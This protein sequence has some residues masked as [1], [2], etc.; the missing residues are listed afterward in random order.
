MKKKWVSFFLFYFITFCA[1]AQTEGYNYYSKLDTVKSSGFYNIALTPEIN[2]HL[3]T[4][5]S[6]IRIVNDSGKWVPHVFRV[7]QTEWN[8]DAVLWSMPVIKKENNLLSTL[9]VVKNNGSAISGI[10]INIRNTQVER[11]CTLTG[12]DD[13]TNWF[14]INDS[15]LLKPEPAY[16]KYQSFLK[17]NFPPATY[18][19]FKLGI[20]NKGK[21]PLNIVNVYS[22]ATPPDMKKPDVH[23]YLPFENPHTVIVQKDSGELSFVKVTQGTAYHFDIISLKTDGAKYF[24]RMVDMYVPSDSNQSFAHPGTLVSSF[25]IS[26]NSTLR[27]YPPAT[28]TKVFYLLIHNQDNPPLRLT[29]V[30]TYSTYHMLTAYLEHGRIYRLLLDNPDATKPHFDLSGDFDTLENRF[31]NTIPYLQ[32]GKIEETEK[33]ISKKQTTS[34]NNKLILWSAIVIAIIILLFFTS[35]MLKEVDKRRSA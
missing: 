2:A 19:Y 9:C 23:E 25:T 17:L 20:N 6:D 12:S 15:I 21:E 30:K 14:I 8:V 22:E 18:K 5:Y 16:N 13:L 33:K 32:A 7:P 26:N 28:N 31:K 27:F 11:F 4:D 29:E 1:N 34:A 3:K 10:Q 24:Y 35:K